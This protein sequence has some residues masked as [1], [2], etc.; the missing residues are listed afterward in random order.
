MSLSHHPPTP[1]TA[2]MAPQHQLAFALPSLTRPRT[3]DSAIPRGSAP[4]LKPGALWAGGGPSRQGPFWNDSVDGK[5]LPQ[6]FTVAPP[7][8]QR[9]RCRR[10]IFSRRHSSISD[11][12][13]A[14]L[15]GDESDDDTQVDTGYSL[16]AVDVLDDA[17]LGGEEGQ[18]VGDERIKEAAD[19]TEEAAQVEYSGDE[20][21]A[22]ALYYQAADEDDDEEGFEFDESTLQELKFLDDEQNA[23]LDELEF[24][25]DLGILDDD[26]FLMKIDDDLVIKAKRVGNFDEDSVDDDDDDDNDSDG[27]FIM[28]ELELAGAF[29]ED[30]KDYRA[31]DD[32]L[33]LEILGL[34]DQEVGLDEALALDEEEEIIFKATDKDLKKAKQYFDGV[35][36]ENS[37]ATQITKNKTERS[38]E[39][40]DEIVPQFSFQPLESALELGV[41]PT[42]AGV[43]S[44]ALPGDFGFDP[45]GFSE[46]DWFKQ[47]QKSLLSVVP[48]KTRGKEEKVAQGYDG[49]AIP[50]SMRVTTFDDME[51]RP[52]SLIIRD[53]REAEIRH[54]RLVSKRN[55]FILFS[56]FAYFL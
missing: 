54:G 43:G 21:D 15:S 33:L 13:A 40:G 1:V 9:E 56:S 47:V 22:D 52:A 14:S 18:D 44:G 51:Q 32:D 39:Q 37:R 17:A 3:G 49:S 34:P 16:E 7:R 11:D 28:E 30:G 25:E 36:E 26:E 2:V 12:D 55:I 41:V 5:F 6:H 38:K 42:E 45:F 4:F 27:I 35:F 46:R 20:D 31:L 24:A 50:E 53:Y 29:D 23:M 10:D 48:E 19:Y 8:G